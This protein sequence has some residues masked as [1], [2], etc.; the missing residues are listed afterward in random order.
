MMRPTSIREVAERTAAETQLF[1]VAVREFLDAGQSMQPTEMAASIADEP[2]PLGAVQ[3]AYLAALAEH[4][5]LTRRFPI[6]AW[7]EQAGRVF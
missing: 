3:D 2:R 4:I 6:T 5:A 1:D 7:V